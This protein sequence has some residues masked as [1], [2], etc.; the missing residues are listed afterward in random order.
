VTDDF[1]QR[2]CAERAEVVEGLLQEGQ[3]AAFGGAFGMGKSPLLADLTVRLVH[4]LEWCG[5]KLEKRPVIALDFETAGPD[6]KRAIQRNATR[7]RVPVP[8]VPEELDVYLEHDDISEPGTAA[9]MQAL[10]QPKIEARLQLL[11]SA[12][13]RKPDAIVMIDPLEM[14]FRVDTTKK[15]HVLALYRA[16]RT[17]LAPFPKAALICTFNL[18]KRN[19]KGEQPDLAFNPRDWLEEI[20]GSLDLMNRADV[21]LGMDTRGDDVRIVN[22]IVRGREMHPILIRPF[23]NSDD[24]LAGFERITPDELALE[25]G[26]G[27]STTQKTHW[28]AL[29]Q[30]FRFEEVADK[31]VPRSSLS[32]LIKHMTSL[33][34]LAKGQ[35]GIFRK[36]ISG[37][38]GGT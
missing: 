21:R 11:E 37:A 19:R 12:L 9:L 15:P 7:L 22:G 10:S 32:R 3:L 14:L 1:F 38:H 16:L 2:N 27:L 29:P 6:Y 13:K 34:A 31:L 5:R 26:S 35:D 25:T 8:R 30:E 17:L 4:G 23:V 28:K 36:Q 33:G 18:R 20:C 24:Q